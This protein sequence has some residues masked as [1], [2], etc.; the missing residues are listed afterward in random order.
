MVDHDFASK[1]ALLLHVTNCPIFTTTFAIYAISGD[2][3][4]AFDTDIIGYVEKVWNELDISKT[5]IDVYKK[6]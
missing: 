5:P 3:E 6:C 2:G 4:T 1:V